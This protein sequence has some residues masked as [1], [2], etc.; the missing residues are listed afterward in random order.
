VIAIGAVK[1]IFRTGRAWGTAR[2][3]A[4]TVRRSA[5]TVPVG[6]ALAAGAASG[7]AGAY[8][9]DPK[10]G[11]RRRRAIGRRVPA[12]RRA[13]ALVRGEASRE[14]AEERAETETARKAAG[15][16]A[17]APAAARETIAA[18]A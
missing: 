10:N 6:A 1:A 8:F 11:Q 13:V 14:E 7:A 16:G 18:G 4:A 12:I 3:R 9:L 2:T 15:N 5:P 17:G